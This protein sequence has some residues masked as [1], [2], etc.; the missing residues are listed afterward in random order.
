VCCWACTHLLY[1]DKLLPKS[2]CQ[3]HH[4]KMHTWHRG[5]L[6][7]PKTP[8]TAPTA[9]PP[10]RPHHTCPY[11]PPT[12]PRDTPAR[13]DPPIA[14]LP[15]PQYSAGPAL[16]P[17]PP[18]GLVP[19]HANPHLPLIPHNRH[20]VPSPHPKCCET[21]KHTCQG[22]PACCGLAPRGAVQ[23]QHWAHN[24]RHTLVC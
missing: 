20:S 5:P 9:R 12:P 2:C 1:V 10:P 19:H 4:A 13:A 24:L 3:L 17:P 6:H 14:G 21:H 7:G 11:P 23:G 16:A 8:H 22:R 15:P 18:P